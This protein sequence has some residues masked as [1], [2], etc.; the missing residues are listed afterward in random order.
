M[1]A[2]LDGILVADF[3]RVLAG[4]L[5]TLY[6]ADLG[7]TVIKVERPGS[8]DDTRSWGPPWATE[9]SSYF[10]SVNRS[11]YSV[12]LDLTNAADRS[13]ASSL[14]EHAD[15]V[16]QN[17][18][19]F[20]LEK[21]RLDYKSVSAANDRV[22]YCSISGFGSAPAA[23]DYLGYDFLVQAMG[24]LMSITGA[25]DGEPT[26]AGV[27]LVDVLTGKDAVIG[28]LAALVN[29]ARTGTGEHVQV[30]LMSSLLAGLVNQ[31]AACLTTGVAPTR[32]GN[33]HPSIAPYETFRCSDAPLAIACGNDAQFRRLADCLGVPELADDPRFR[34][35]PL[36]VAH[37]DELAVA[38]EARIAFDTAT[39]WAHI[40][41]AAGVPAGT[42]NDISAA[43]EQATDLGLEPTISVGEP[44]ARQIRNP[45]RLGRSDLA[46]PAPPPA[47]GADNRRVREWIRTGMT[48]P[49]S[50]PSAA[51]ER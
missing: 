50:H 40:I 46:D 18:R 8:G 37:R 24:G 14:A 31:S 49:L 51:T 22:I 19:P 17:F 35:N 39:H 15:V 47:V 21:Y 23:R 10:E 28:I 44:Y 1:A 29:R 9:T 4:P 2:P 33:R 25:P 41:T 34:T 48:E 12:E 13:V 45:I 42:V 11:K 32:M 43:I 36:R 5:A 3:S 7:A 16:V 26:K 30:D 27:A 38:I 6:L 20:A